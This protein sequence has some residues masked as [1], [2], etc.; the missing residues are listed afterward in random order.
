M[1][2]K[3]SLL[4]IMLGVINLVGGLIHLVFEFSLLNHETIYRGFLLIENLLIGLLYIYFAFQLLY[5]DWQQKV[6]AVKNNIVFWLCFT[7]AVWVFQPEIT[8]LNIVKDLLPVPQKNVLL[9]I[10]M[11]AF[12]VSTLSLQ[13]AHKAFSKEISR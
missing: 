13:E 11:I 2:N 5:G 1:E 10:G 8:S 7:I 3:K 12:F 6:L 9:V 4:F